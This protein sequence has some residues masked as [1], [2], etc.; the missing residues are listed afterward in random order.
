[1]FHFG[2]P[3]ADDALIRRARDLAPVLAGRAEETERLRRI[4]D[5][6][7]AD[8][9]EAGFFRNPNELAVIHL[10]WRGGPEGGSEWP[11]HER[12]TT[13]EFLARFVQGGE[14]L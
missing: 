14:H 6:T 11:F 3:R 2:S 12:L 4:P 9:H 10:T 7:I 1:M 5:A 8:L 13:P